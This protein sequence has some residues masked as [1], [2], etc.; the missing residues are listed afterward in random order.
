MN[1]RRVLVDDKMSIAEQIEAH[2]VAREAELL[3]LAESGSGHRCW[4]LGTNDDDTKFVLTIYGSLTLE[5]KR[6]ITDI[7]CEIDASPVAPKGQQ[8]VARLALPKT[9]DGNRCTCSKCWVDYPYF[10][11]CPDCGNKRCPKA[12]NHK[13]ACTSSNEPGQKGSN[14]E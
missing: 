14:Y 2:E 9:L 7:A 6:R 5:Q 4:M 12:A 11:V 10:R 13:N 1:T 3:D 8:A